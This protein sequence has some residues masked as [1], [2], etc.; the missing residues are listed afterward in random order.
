MHE[1]HIET[2]AASPEGCDPNHEAAPGTRNRRRFGPAVGVDD[3]RDR[4]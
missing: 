2:S 1:S 4:H 3:A